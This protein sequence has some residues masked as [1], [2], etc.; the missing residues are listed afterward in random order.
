MQ[1]TKRRSYCFASDL[2]KFKKDL[3]NYSETGTRLLSNTS[4][5]PLTDNQYDIVDVVLYI[6]TESTILA[7]FHTATGRKKK[8][9]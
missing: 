9:V 8:I 5:D 3:V 7:F 6:A 4:F 1:K 2:Y